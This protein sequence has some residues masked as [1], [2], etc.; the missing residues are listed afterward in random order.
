MRIHALQH[1]SFE[2]P[3]RISEW[4]EARGHSIAVTHLYRGEEL[5]DPAYFELLVMMGGPM[6]VNDEAAHPWLVREKR[7]VAELAAAN[8]PMLGVCLGAQLIAA[9]LGA[10]VYAAAEKEIGWFPVRWLRL[11]DA[12]A[13]DS[14]LLERAVPLSWHGET[15]DLPAGAVRLAESDV[16]PNQAFGLEDRIL[17]LQFHLEATARSVRALAEHAADDITGGA[18]QQSASEIAASAGPRSEATRPL[19][20]ALLDALASKAGE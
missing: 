19:L 15:F 20:Y 12:V 9:S 8:K 6:S 13:A 14:A 5:P 3:A 2:E 10:A 1:V 4:A 7:F 18:Y 17:G 11:P 16:C